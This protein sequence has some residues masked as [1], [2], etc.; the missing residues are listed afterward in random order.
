LPGQRKNELQ[1]EKKM[2][3]IEYLNILWSRR[4][5][6]FFTV[7]VTTAFVAAGTYTISPVYSAETTIR[8]ASH[9]LTSSSYS[10]Y[11]YV[12]RLLNTYIYLS[13]SQPVLDELENRLGSARTPFVE[14]EILPNTELI[15][16]SVEYEDPHQAAEAANTLA[17]ILVEQSRELYSGGRK[18]LNAVLL[19]QLALSELDL[20]QAR[21]EV[22]RL[23]IKDPEDVQGLT[24][25]RQALALREESYRLVLEQYGNS[26]VRD[27]IRDNMVSI[28]EPAVPPSLP[29][30]P[31]PFLNLLVG[32]AAGL[33]G[34]I[35]L[36]FLFDHLLPSL[37]KMGEDK[38]LS[39]VPETGGQGS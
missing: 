8:V 27:A 13:T 31:R 19:E 30:R 29:S 26:R 25:A 24:E 34:G 35:F 15:Q 17:A 7:V 22:E 14:A 11:L 32:S 1:R 4:W 3:L 33:C 39:P 23:L 12:E 2:E 6:I 38:R 20:Q 16:I 28:V 21:S 36:S 10:D 5:F 37:R 9:N 18:S